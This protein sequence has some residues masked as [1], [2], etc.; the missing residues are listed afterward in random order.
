MSYGI[1][2]V[3]GSQSNDSVEFYKNALKQQLCEASSK[4]TA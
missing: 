3:Q 4:L 1:T 2:T